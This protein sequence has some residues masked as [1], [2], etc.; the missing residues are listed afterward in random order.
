MTKSE[1]YKLH[2]EQFEGQ[3]WERC[4]CGNEPVNMPSHLCIDCLMRG[5]DT[6][7]TD[8]TPRDPYRRGCG[9]GFGPGDDGDV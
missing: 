6:P 3:L 2:P 9:Q 7:Q 5:K 4:R 1:F 8:L